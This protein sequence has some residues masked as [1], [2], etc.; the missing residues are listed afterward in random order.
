MAKAYPLSMNQFSLFTAS[1]KPGKCNGKIGS[2]VEEAK[3]RDRKGIMNEEGYIQGLFLS[4]SL[5][6]FSLS[7][8][9]FLQLSFAFPRSIYF[10]LLPLLPLPPPPLLLLLLLLFLCAPGVSTMVSFTCTFFSVMSV[11]RLVMRT[12]FS[13]RCSAARRVLS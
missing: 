4:F 1:E 6:S 2:M 5:G 13:T 3:R 7:I 8:C 10:S 12:V 11:V 9:P